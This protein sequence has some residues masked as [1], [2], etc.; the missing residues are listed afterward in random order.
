MATLV[1]SPVNSTLSLSGNQGQI[2]L[3]Y[4]IND[5]D[6]S[7][8][9]T[10]IA[11]AG[12]EIYFSDEIQIDEDAITFP[13]SVGT[14][15]TLGGRILLDDNGNADS[16]PDTTNSLVLTFQPLSVSETETSFISIPFTTTATF[17]GEAQLNFI[18]REATNNLE[19]ADVSP[20]TI[21][22]PTL[23]I[24]PESQTVSSGTGQIVLNYR[25]A[26]FGAAQVGS[27]GIEIYF[28]STE[29]QID[30]D[31]ITFPGTVGDIP[32][33]GGRVLVA[34]GANEDGDVNTDSF[35]LLTFN[36]LNVSA[37]DTP[38]ITIPF[39]TTAAFDGEAN[40][41]FI[42]REAT[43]GLGAADVDSVTITGASTI[44]TLVITPESQTVS[45]G[46]GQIVLN[47]RLDNFDAAQVASAG[48]EIY[49]DSDEIQ[50]DE[51]AITFPSTVGS[52]PTIGGRISGSDTE[53]EDGDAATGNFVLLTFNPLIVS[54]EDTLLITIPFTTT[55]A[56]DGAAN[57]NFIARESTDGLEVAA[58]DSVTVANA[59]P[60]ITSTTFT[61]AENTTTVG[62]IAA[63]DADGDTLA[64]SLIGGADQA[65]FAINATTGA[66]S[67]ITAPDF[68]APTDAGANNVYNVQVQVTDGIAVD[69]QDIAVTVTDEAT[70]V[71]TPQS[72]TVS[73]SDGQIVLNYRLDNFNAAQVASAGIEIYFDSDEIQID[74]DAITFPN[75]VGSVP[76]IGG[77]VLVDDGANEDGDDNTNNFVLLTFNPLN[78]PTEETVLITIPFTT[79][80]AFDGEAK[81]NFIPRE[82]TAGLEAA[83]IDSVTVQGSTGN[84]PPTIVAPTNFVVEFAEN[85]TAVVL[86][87]DA[88]DPENDA[89]TFALVV[90]VDAD[91]FTISD[92]GQITFR[93]TPNF[94]APADN[95]GDNVYNLQVQVSDGT[96]PAVT[97]AVTVTV[98]DVNE[99]PTAVTLTNT[100]PTLAEDT[101]TAVRIKVANINVTDDAQGTETIA[102]SG[103]DAALFEVVGTELYLKADAALDFETNPQ[104][105]VTVSVIDEALSGSTPVTANLTI[106]V[107][108]VDE[109]LE[110]NFDPAEDGTIESGLIFNPNF[111][112]NVILDKSDRPDAGRQVDGGT[113]AVFDNLVGLYE[114]LDVQGSVLD[115]EGNIL[116]PGT[117]GFD[118]SEYALAALNARVENFT[119]R[120]GA[121][122]KTA[123]Q[124]GDV[125]LN[126]G[127][128]Y[129]PFI[130]ANGGAIG[131]QGF[132]NA[133]N[134][135]TSVFNN[136]ATTLNDAVAYFS[137]I[138][139]NPDGVAH[140]RSYGNGVFGFEDLP[141]NL[142][143]SNGLTVSDGDFNDAVFAF[144]L[145]AAA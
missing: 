37:E 33:T 12:F 122:R 49:F 60:V 17:D 130:I 93:Q 63:T 120:A 44:P 48:I 59:A 79:T 112:G 69:T 42:P 106:A 105:D 72:P 54:A 16:D 109:E 141:S 104:L 80:A 7:F 71:I 36:P 128:F 3:N 13:S 53:N 121:S 66:L 35:V 133:E 102:L 108:D 11:S 135:E 41:N 114:V 15:P 134:A 90:G 131:V 23:V 27:A 107:T 31:A 28:D 19:A 99:A 124:I 10:Q 86:D 56:F 2:D 5:L 118:P 32:D 76:T 82:A 96:N 87:I 4:V 68:E 132:I 85:S 14:I 47:Y 89:I 113:E 62:T 21:T 94:E 58:I 84:Q 127:S 75:T 126:G 98:T 119:L 55:A 26:N 29:I 43:A 24:T 83:A 137:F 91:L 100:V 9:A 25:L 116:T 61:I 64:Y 103:D 144:N 125:L 70:L 8:S 101:D 115:A 30:I 88:T 34:D 142:I 77:R 73:S 40:V 20:V 22:A 50:I 38:L 136:A 140:L 78:V 129:A 111:D 117:D 18:S 67:F 138:D 46:T 123:E 143:G 74:E 81:V 139:A 6:N 1:V 57:V 145:T 45:S 39:T 52:V 97:Q 65:L 95:G 110:L 51:D 92:Q